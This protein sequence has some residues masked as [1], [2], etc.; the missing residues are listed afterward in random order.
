MI[1]GQLK[2]QN[3]FLSVVFI[4]DSSDNVKVL[5]LSALYSRLPVI[6]ISLIVALAGITAFVT[7]TFYENI[8]LRVS[9]HQLKHDNSSKSGIISEK[10]KEINTLKE[11]EE[12][13]NSKIME[14]NKKFREMTDSY[15]SNRSGDVRTS[16]AS[17]RND[18]LFLDD[19]NELKS[20][21]EDLNEASSTNVGEGPDLSDVT[22]KLEDYKKRVPTHWPASGRVS[23]YFGGRPDPF[24]NRK[25]QH[26]G[27]DIAAGYGQ[28]IRA[29]ANGKVVY[30][31][32][33]SG[34]GYTVIID[35]GNGLSTLYAHASKLLVKKGSI[36]KMGQE[37]AKVGSSGR[38]TGAHL[39][40]EVR[41]NGQQVDPLKYLD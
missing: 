35:H 4:P 5:K 13:Y 40:F 3:K 38:S 28:G 25:K 34:Y 30:S 17:D 6:L 29:S 37:I 21:V 15:L 36:V 18:K 8:K 1:K 23:S 2:K 33:Y 26:E 24:S 32:Y 11:K 39:H 19:A 16:R 9:V 20:L 7:Y 31:D 12:Q 14:I 22:G 27:I 10:D 41:V